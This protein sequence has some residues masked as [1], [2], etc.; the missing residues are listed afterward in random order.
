MKIY[1]INRPI[2]QIEQKC[3]FTLKILKLKISYFNSICVIFLGDIKL[4]NIYSVSQIDE[5]QI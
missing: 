1:L 3:L 5:V 2:V 4:N